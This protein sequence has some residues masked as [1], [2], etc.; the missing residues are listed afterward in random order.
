MHCS[1]CK[2]IGLEENFIFIQ[3]DDVRGYEVPICFDCATEE[4]LKMQWGNEIENP[5]HPQKED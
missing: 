4:E 3:T 1:I 2:K 5:P